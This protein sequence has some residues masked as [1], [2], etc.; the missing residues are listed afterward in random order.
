MSDR[1]IPRLSIDLTEDQAQGL[2][3]VIGEYGMKKQV[4]HLLINDLIETCD[5]FGTGMV[6]GALVERAIG[7]KEISKLKL[8]EK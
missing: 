1:Y 7:I 4:F 8:K 5:R 3:R 6:I 2:N